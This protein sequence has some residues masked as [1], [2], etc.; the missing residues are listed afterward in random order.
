MLSI[1]IP[2]VFLLLLVPSSQNA[3]STQDTDKPE[4]KSYVRIIGNGQPNARI[5]LPS[6]ADST[7]LFA[8]GE[9]QRYLEKVSGVRLPVQSRGD[10]R[11][12]G[13]EIRFEVKPELKVKFDGY[14]IEVKPSVIRLTAREPRG[15]LYA[16][17][18]LLKEIGCSFVYPGE[19][20]EV[21]PRLGLVKFPLGERVEEPLIEH[22][23]LAFYG[24][25][26]TSVELGGK[27]IDWMAKNRFNLLLVSEDRPSDVQGN[28]HAI[29]WREVAQDLLPEVQKRGFIIDMSEHSTHV[30]FPR[31][32]FAEHPEWF[33]LNDGK[34]TPGQIC[35]SNEEAIEY[36][37]RSQAAYAAQHPEIHILGTWPLDGGG[38]CE[39][40]SCR[41]PET[42]F[43]AAAGVAD[44]VRSVR[45]DL[46]V[47]HLAYKLQT[48]QV[49]ET[50]PVPE[51]LSVLFC[52]SS[53]DSLARSWVEATEQAR[54]TYLFEYRTGDNYHFLTNVWLRPEYAK[55]I[56]GQAVDV[57]YRGVISLY[58]PIQNW[59]RTSFNEYFLAAA[60]WDNEL[61]L[62]EE[63]DRYCRM[64]Y[65]GHARQ[66][67]QIFRIILTRLQNDYLHGAHNAL[68][69]KNGDPL[70][71]EGLEITLKA[72]DEIKSIIDRIR[73]KK[74]GPQVSRRI[75][76]LALFVDYFALYYR[77]Y[78]SLQ[79][80]DLDKLVEFSRRHSE[81]GGS[82][83]IYPEY[84]EER[85]REYY[86]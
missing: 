74:T 81:S 47:E 50:V 24:L 38:Y 63:L 51:N 45:P 60:Y 65:G 20:E 82:V 69:G 79:A 61:D 22:R 83:V 84:I 16:A 35:Y 58:V 10:S 30:F 76:R 31:S 66:V 33:A 36:Y 39:C 1:S 72:A 4:S 11:S 5:Y 64:Y 8:A 9:L 14:R 37:A 40:E 43:K 21:I 41:S 56:A 6:P 59:W 52:P 25:D 75:E 68:D 78:S 15:L 77:C 13:V 29:I 12:E 55:M 23:G 34:R 32:L 67:R 49:P 54:G 70:S 2:L 80:A 57:G 73:R 71:P 44:Q 3:L 86:R 26:K 85:K 28:A 42:V 46:T 62:E 7:V 53:R 18:A 48:W 19:E 27:I 17:Y